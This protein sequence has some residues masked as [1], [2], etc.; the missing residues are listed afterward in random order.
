M[1]FLEAGCHS[2]LYLKLEFGVGE[3]KVG[4]MYMSEPKGEESVLTLLIC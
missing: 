2:E 3:S 1:F 4:S